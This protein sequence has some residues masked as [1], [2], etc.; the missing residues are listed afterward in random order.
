MRREARDVRLVWLSLVW[1]SGDAVERDMYSW[2][3]LGTRRGIWAG[4]LGCKIDMQSPD[5]KI[6]TCLCA[7]TETAF[8]PN[9]SFVVEVVSLCLSQEILSAGAPPGQSSR[10]H[11]A[12]FSL[13][14]LCA[15]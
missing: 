15:R 14:D 12:V 13:P 4:V 2:R 6:L 11:R 9:V 8:P 5:P 10:R 1:C 7:S 3:R